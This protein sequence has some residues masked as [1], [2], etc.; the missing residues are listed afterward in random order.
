MRLLFLVCTLFVTLLHAQTVATSENIKRIK[1]NYKAFLLSDNT[2]SK[3]L[4]QKE[5][6]SLPNE[7]I[8]SDQMVV[9]LLQ[10]RELPHSVIQ[11]Y[12]KGIQPDGSW[13]DIHYEDTRRSG[14]D[15]RRHAERVLILAKIYT[16]YQSPFY[17]SPEVLEVIHKALRFWF[18][19]QPVC[20]NW[21]YNQIGIPKSFAGAFILLEDLLTEEEKNGA[22][23]VMGQAKIGMTGQNKVWL[24]ANVLVKGLLQNDTTLVTEAR[25]AIVSEIVT[26][27][28]EGIQNDWSFHQ[29][30]PQQQFGN[31]GLAFLSSM[32]EYASVFKNTSLAFTD[33][34]TDILGKLLSEGYRRI[35]WKGFMDVNALD[36]QLFHN[37]S[38]HK[39]F[40]TAMAASALAA[41]GN[42]EIEKTANDLIRENYI[43]NQTTTITGTKHFWNSDQTIHRTKQWMASVKMCSERVIGTEVVN[44]DN[45]LGYYMG[46]GATYTYVEGDEYFNIFPL[47]DWR[48]IPGVTAY[49]GS[50]NLPLAYGSKSMNH[51]SFVGGVYNG[52]TGLSVMKLNRNG[53]HANKLWIFTDVGV[54]CLGSAIHSDSSAFV[55]TSI[56][57]R[58]KKD[59]LWVSQNKRWNTITDTVSFGEK[60]VRFFHKNTGY[61]VWPQTCSSAFSGKREGDWS[62]FM[63]SYPPLKDTGNLVAI[64]LNHGKQ[65][66]KAG[67]QYLI[68]P[69]MNRDAVESFDMKSFQILRN[70]S[71]AQIVLSKDKQTAWLAIYSPQLVKVGKQRFHIKTNGLYLIENV[72][73]DP[74]IYYADP[75]QKNQT[76]EVHLGKRLWKGSSEKGKTTLLSVIKTY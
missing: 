11:S 16:T 43:P 5:I 27:E 68:L 41:T 21:W 44:E 57:Q 51:S 54:L 38:K 12:L 52:K 25:D 58:L 59:T 42:K 3:D 34:D 22:I 75:T 20:K 50:R 19:T 65:P 8:L 66:K 1:G 15:A 28:K 40:T 24:A 53:L 56:D 61:I 71:S 10:H 6:N 36:R 14:W 31:Y 30:G 74:C 2:V 49:E 29:H 18:A 70:D 73:T 46:D 35:L 37:V 4:L 67:Y 32:A 62:K 72:A 76:A 60:P 9:E 45:W 33:H 13:K 47:W 55:T 63:K 17:H 64:T 26:G 48:K 39:G 69:D 23:R 7:A